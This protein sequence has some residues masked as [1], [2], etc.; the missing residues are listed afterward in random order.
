Y[1]AFF[2]KGPPNSKR[3]ADRSLSAKSASPR[4]LKRSYKEAVR[5]GAG[6][7]SSMAALMV[8]R[9]SPESETW[10]ANSAKAGLLVK[11]AA[12]RSSSQD[13]MTLPRRQTSATSERV[14]SY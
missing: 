7:P 6:T 13:E 12:V 10:P 5:T 4:E 1:L 3:I 9:P 14:K 2:S 8:Q 11:A